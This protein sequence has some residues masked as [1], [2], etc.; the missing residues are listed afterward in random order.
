MP[1]GGINIFHRSIILLGEQVY[2]LDESPYRLKVL[3]RLGVIPYRKKKSRQKMTNFFAREEF[4]CQLFV[5]PT[6]NFY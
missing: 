3:P 1:S 5:L 4:F 2:H 6:I